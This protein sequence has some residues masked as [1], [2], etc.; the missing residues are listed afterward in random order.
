MLVLIGPTTVASK[1]H[2]SGLAFALD[3]DG[4]C[5][6]IRLRPGLDLRSGG[7]PRK[8][9]T[10]SSEPHP[11]VQV[12]IYPKTDPNQHTPM[13]I[14]LSAFWPLL[15]TSWAILNV[16][17]GLLGIVGLFLLSTLTRRTHPIFGALGPPARTE[18]G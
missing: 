18:E 12:S 11:K 4:Y 5:I 17:L 16:S 10:P 15:H 6:K 7:R 9:L 14:F 13:H 1:T 3:L 8:D 2:D